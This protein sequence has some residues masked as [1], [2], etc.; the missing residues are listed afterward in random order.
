MTGHFFFFLDFFF[1]VFFGRQ[2]CLLLLLYVGKTALINELHTSVEQFTGIKHFCKNTIS[3][4][5]ITPSWKL[6]VYVG[7]ADPFIQNVGIKKSEH[8]GTI[9]PQFPQSIFQ[10][11]QIECTA[12][13]RTFLLLRPELRA[14]CITY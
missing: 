9:L 6:R 14:S 8:K 1:V 7:S 11:T 3:S 13:A 5:I 4:P 2:G 10:E 12:L